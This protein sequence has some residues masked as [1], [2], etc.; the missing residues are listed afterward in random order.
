MNAQ[1]K[2][3]GEYSFDFD[4]SNLLAGYYLCTLSAGNIFVTEK[5]LIT[6]QY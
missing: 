2:G 5:I 4:S 6:R 3:E 1:K